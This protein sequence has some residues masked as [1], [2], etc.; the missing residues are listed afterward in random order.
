MKKILKSVIVLALCSA[1][2]YT[3]TTTKLRKARKSVYTFLV[4]TALMLPSCVPLARNTPRIT[5]IIEDYNC[6]KGYSACRA[7]VRV[8]VVH[9]Y[10]D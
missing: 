6:R 9:V 5:R 4:F 2:S 10:H 7:R 8:E 1:P 3:A